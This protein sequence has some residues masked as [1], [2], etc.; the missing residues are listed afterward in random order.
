MHMQFQCNFIVF[1][2]HFSVAQMQNAAHS[3]LI[4]ICETEISIIQSALHFFFLCTSWKHFSTMFFA[5]W[6]IVYSRMQRFQI[7]KSTGTICCPT[8]HSGTTIVVLHHLQIYIEHLPYITFCFFCLNRVCCK[9][10]HF[11]PLCINND[12]ADFFL[13]VFAKWMEE[14]AGTI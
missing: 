4:K 13:S 9:V 10:I 7:I 3:L 12:Y 11:V 14:M 6:Y 2:D 5:A 8:H 1:H